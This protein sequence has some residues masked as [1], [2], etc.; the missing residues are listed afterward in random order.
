MSYLLSEIYLTQPGASGI[1]TYTG[2]TGA[3]GPSSGTGGGATGSTGA[4]G[5]QGV[6]GATGLTGPEGASGATGP[7][8]P[9]GSSSISLASYSWENNYYVLNKATDNFIKFDNELFNSSST[10]F[11]L[12]N[13]GSDDA[14]IFI[15]EDGVYE[16]DAQIHIQDLSLNLEPYDIVVKLFKSDT[17]NGPSYLCGLLYNNKYIEKNSSG[18]LQG[19][20]LEVV[21][22]SGGYYSIAIMPINVSPFIS[23]NYS[24]STR[25]YIKKLI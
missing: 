15:K 9:S 19:K 21:S 24:T 10:T 20:S 2:A 7:I 11:E 23:K 25:I 12:K 3:T 6:M 5:L 22:L 18:L 1:I 17:E 4:T 14:R 13:S 8:G 16:F